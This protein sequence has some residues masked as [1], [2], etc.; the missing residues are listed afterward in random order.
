MDRAVGPTAARQFCAFLLKILLGWLTVQT[1]AAGQPGGYDPS[2]VSSEAVRYIDLSFGDA[3]RARELP[4]RAYL[5]QA[6]VPAP[7]SPVQP[8]SGRQPRRQR[9]SWATL[10]GAWLS[11]RLPAASGQRR[12]RSGRSGLRR[13][14]WTRCRQAASIENFIARVGD[15]SATL[16]Q[17]ERWHTTEGHELFGRV[18]LSR[19][20]MSGHSFGALTTQA[21]S[22][23]A[24]SQ[25]VRP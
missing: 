1:L 5:P 17:L 8:W 14:V 2:I 4:I 25:A 7:V 10:G 15:V 19:I 3:A 22:G 20:G 13:N 24:S 23:Q 9:L 6:R 18:D 21:V 16:N 11:G 12:I